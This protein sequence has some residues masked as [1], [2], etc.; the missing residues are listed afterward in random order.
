MNIKPLRRYHT[1]QHPS[2]GLIVVDNCNRIV[3]L[4]HAHYFRGDPPPRKP[5]ASPLKQIG[6]RRSDYSNAIRVR[7][8]YE[9]SWILHQSTISVVGDAEFV[10]H[11]NQVGDGFR[12]HFLHDLRAMRFDG[13]F[14]GT[15]FE[16]DLFVERAASY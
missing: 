13:A 3:Y 5:I 12:L 14:A 15:E 9:G 8:L 4:R 2:H 10:G 6:L 1:T 11:A 7:K 16:R